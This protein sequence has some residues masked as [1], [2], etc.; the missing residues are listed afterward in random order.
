MEASNDAVAVDDPEESETAGITIWNYYK[1]TGVQSKYGGAKNI[2][3]SFC[4]ISFTGCSSSSA[5][6][7][8]L[9]RKVLDQTKIQP[10]GILVWCKTQP[11]G[12]QNL[13][14]YT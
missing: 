3:C 7:H 9:G 6:A 10:W 2:I 8:I 5:F 12:V 1:I 11:W 4:N 13:Y 14:S